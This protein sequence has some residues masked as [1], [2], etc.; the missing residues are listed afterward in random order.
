M[1]SQAYPNMICQNRIVQ[2]KGGVHRDPRCSLRC[3]DNWARRESDLIITQLQSVQQSHLVYFGNVQFKGPLSKED[4]LRIR[5]HF[6]NSLRKLRSLNGDIEFRACSEVGDNGLV[7][8]HY[9]LY[10][11]FL[12]PDSLM[13]S[14]WDAVASPFR[15]IVFHQPAKDVIAISKYMF[16]DL[17][18]IRERRQWINLFEYGTMP[19]TWQSRHFFRPSRKFIMKTAGYKR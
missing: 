17:K 7:H 10:A 1:F 14:I 5:K 4:H 3:R 16:K 9:S 15:T 13:K 12:I 8:Y 18:A 2:K 19:I 6:L 11:S